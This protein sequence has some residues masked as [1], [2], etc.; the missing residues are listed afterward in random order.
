MGAIT[1]YKRIKQVVDFTGL[2]QGFTP[3]DIDGLIEFRDKAYVFI[4]IKTGNAPLP[5][6]QKLAIERLVRDTGKEKKSIG[7]VASHNIYN[8]RMNIIAA[9]CIVRN[10]YSSED[11]QWRD[12]HGICLRDCIR[13]FISQI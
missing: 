7:I 11:L 5:F 3:T 4:E 6:G 12:V 13:W 2:C 9:E 1:N 10:I 8:S